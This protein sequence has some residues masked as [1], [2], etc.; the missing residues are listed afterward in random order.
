MAIGLALFLY[1]IKRRTHG[2]VRQAVSPWPPSTRDP[3]R[4]VWITI[5]RWVD[6]LREGTL[7]GRLEGIGAPYWC[8]RA[9][10][11]RAAHVMSRAGDC[12]DPQPMS[13]VF[14]GAAQFY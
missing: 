6:A 3:A 1:G 8:R 4:T 12:A 10:A 13:Q 11:E 5:G 2:Q 9:V 7:F 14:F